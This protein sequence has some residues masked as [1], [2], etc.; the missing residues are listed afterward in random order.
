LKS[1]NSV[2]VKIIT[3][4]VIAAIIGVV[5]YGNSLEKRIDRHDVEIAKIGKDIEYIKIGVE[6]LLRRTQGDK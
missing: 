4:L 3:T 5:G 2:A 1:K 6:E